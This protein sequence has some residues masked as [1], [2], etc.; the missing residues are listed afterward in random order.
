[1]QVISIKEKL[2]NGATSIGS[3]MQIPDTNVA[4]IMGKAGYDWIVLDLEHGLFNLDKL[5]DICRALELGK[6]IPFARIGENNPFYIKQVL[7]AGV[8]GI[9][10]PMVNSREDAENLVKWIRYT[11]RGTRGVGYSRA[12]LFG[13]YFK[14]HINK[15]DE[16][17]F[18]VVQIED[19]KAV[20]VIDEIL[21]V[22]GLD[23]LIIGPYDLSASMNL[24]GQFDHPDMVTAIDQIKNAAIKAQVAMG[25]HIVQTDP[26][27]LQ[28]KVD[29]G[30][31]FVAYATDGI[32]MYESFER[33]EIT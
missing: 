32:F 2:K 16:D 14:Q 25:L 10:A 26:V 27:L 31:Q 18:I 29:E 8:R 11:P 19:I 15:S 24:T 23:A 3:W 22:K 5:V 33:P 4:E 6:S 7:E 30:Y 17:L 13:K 28:Q 1:M 9:I 20:N 12:S 21:D